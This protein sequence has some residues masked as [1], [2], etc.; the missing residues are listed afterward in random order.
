MITVT[1][2]RPAGRDAHG[3]PTG[4]GDHTVEVRAVAPGAQRGP[5]ELASG[6]VT[7]VDYTLYGPFDLDIKATDQVRI[8]VP[9]WAGTYDVVGEPDRWQSLAD[10]K[11]GCVVELTRTGG[12]SDG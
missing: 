2:L 4:V 1:V 8:D 6:D 9:A 5:E 10:R 12:T 3:D 7:N 11:A